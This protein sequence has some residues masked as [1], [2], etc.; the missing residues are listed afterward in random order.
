MAELRVPL[1]EIDCR[2]D[3]PPLERRWNDKGLLVFEEDR[4]EGYRRRWYE[5]GVLREELRGDVLAVFTPSGNLAFVRERSVKVGEEPHVAHRFIDSIMLAELDVIASDPELEYHVFLYL[6][7]TLARS[8][9]AGLEVLVRL[10]AHPSASVAGHA[11]DV[12]AQ[13]SG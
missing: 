6:H 4:V 7:A 10:L 3:A 1:N 8:R 12:L 9:P 5:N 2:L 13:I 11:R